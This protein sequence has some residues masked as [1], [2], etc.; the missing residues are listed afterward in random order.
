MNE[1]TDSSIFV[2]NRHKAKQTDHKGAKQ[3]KGH[4]D[5]P[6]S[7]PT[8]QGDGFSGDALDLQAVI[9]HIRHPLS[10]SVPFILPWVS[11]KSNGFRPEDKK[12]CGQKVARLDDLSSEQTVEFL[13]GTGAESQLLPGDRV[14][15]DQLARVETESA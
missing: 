9:L 5:E 3:Q 15:K 7:G 12:P 6:H 1:L 13:G 14:A 10:R 4:R 2:L 11:A 8:A